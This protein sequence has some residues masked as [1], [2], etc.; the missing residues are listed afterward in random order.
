MNEAD[1][2][3]TQSGSSTGRIALIVLLIFLGAFLLVLISTLI[4][5]LLTG[6]NTADAGDPTVAV[7]PPASGAPH[8]VANT[9][10][11]VRSGPGTEYPVYGVA[12][13]G[14][15]AEITGIS[16]DF[17]WYAVKIPADVAPSGQGWVSADYTTAYNFQQV[18]VLPP[19]P[20]PPVVKPPK[21]E[22]S[23]AYGVTTDVINVRAEPSNQSESYGK[24]PVGTQGQIVGISEDGVWYAVSIPTDVASSGI[25]WVN[26]RY[27]DVYNA[28]GVPIMQ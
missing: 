10:V 15:S 27:V 19:P 14:Q 6:G 13:P 17:N 12:S 21:P 28:E 18:P 23:G 2:P 9:H 5:H 1:Q 16:Q 26:A 25:G 4:G 3:Q 7:P 24:V 8:A 11:N 20:P 22:I